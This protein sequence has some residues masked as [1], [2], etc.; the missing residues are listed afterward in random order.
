SYTFLLSIQTKKEA[1]DGDMTDM[2][3]R[4]NFLFRAAGTGASFYLFPHL[5]A[6]KLA[7]ADDSPLPASGSAPVFFSD[8]ERGA[9]ASLCNQIFPDA[10][11]LGAVDYIETLLTA[12]ESD[13]PR[14]FAGGPYSGRKP[15]SQNGEATNQFPPDSFQEFE[16]LT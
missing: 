5:L 8:P 3:S 11:Q 7:Q 15:F 16:P 13:P 6:P 1:K 9:L 2:I 14:I 12:F 4:R 10:A